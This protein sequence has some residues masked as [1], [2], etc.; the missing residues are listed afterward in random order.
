MQRERDNCHCTCRTAVKLIVSPIQSAVCSVSWKYPTSPWVATLSLF[1]PVSRH[2]LIYPVEGKQ[3]QFLLCNEIDILLILHTEYWNIWSPW[4]K[5][6]RWRSCL[7]C[8]MNT[9][10][11]E[12]RWSHLIEIVYIPMNDGTLLFLAQV[13]SISIVNVVP[14]S[15]KDNY[16]W[17]GESAL[18]SLE[19]EASSQVQGDVCAAAPEGGRVWPI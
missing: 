5:M 8:V 17:Q 16:I 2:L 4:P 3:R 13:T 15:R 18:S 6:K 14:H 12:H 7:E 9:E 10:K 1:F 19:L 11:L